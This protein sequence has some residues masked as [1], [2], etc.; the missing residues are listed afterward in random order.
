MINP[1]KAGGRRSHTDEPTPRGGTR[2]RF[3]LP[4]HGAAMCRPRREART[5]CGT[6]SKPAESKREFTPIIR[7]EV[8]ITAPGARSDGGGYAPIDTSR[9]REAAIPGGFAESPFTPAAVIRVWSRAKSLIYRPREGYFF[10]WQAS[11]WGRKPYR[12]AISSADMV[13]CNKL[14]NEKSLLR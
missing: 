10:V 9:D 11:I 14:F 13:S 8:P 2:S 6:S 3:I 12:L 1:A 7:R 4:H 5:P